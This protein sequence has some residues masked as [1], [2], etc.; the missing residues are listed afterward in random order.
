MFRKI[1][2]IIEL[3][4]I[5][6]VIFACYYY[7]NN[8]SNEQFRKAS[9]EVVNIDSNDF[10]IYFLDVGQADCI[11]IK[12]N[13]DYMLIDS[14][15]YE[16]SNYVIDY[17]RKLNINS[18]KYVIATHAHEDHIGGMSKI[19]YNF[20]IDK[21]FMPEV[22][23]NYKSYYNL[24][25]ALLNKKVDVSTPETDYNYYLGDSI[26]QV[27][28]VGT[29]KE[30]LNNTS[31]VLKLKYKET[32]YLFMGD[33]TNEV[34]RQ[35]L[36]KDLKSDVLKVGHHGASTSS[37]AVFLSK[38]KPL[39]AIISVG[40]NNEFNHPKKVTIDKLERLNSTIYRTDID[41]TIILKSN[42]KDIYFETEKTYTNGG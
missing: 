31:I 39:Y 38:V 30:E 11:I 23:S 9:K 27:L 34:E 15:G 14:G 10:V 1:V 42:G 29:D 32:T 41:G 18:F 17:I 28:F 33:A 7:S 3:F 40:K 13:N 5:I 36:D 12:S 21:F 20:S 22:G 35:I 8:T 16:T 24:V 26:F 25:N 19:I 6:L 37:S 2:N 4:I